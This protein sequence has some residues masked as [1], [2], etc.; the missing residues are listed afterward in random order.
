LFTD[1]CRTNIKLYPLL[2]R[3][4]QIVYTVLEFLTAYG[5]ANLSLRRRPWNMLNFL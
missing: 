1:I 5:R 4:Y 2:I 3:G